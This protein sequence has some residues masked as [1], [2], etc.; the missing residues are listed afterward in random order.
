MRTILISLLIALGLS[1][2]TMA[3]A[4]AGLVEDGQAAFSA[5]DYSTA[6]RLRKEAANQ[7]NPDAQNNLGLMYRTGEGV[8]Q[9]D[10][11]AVKWFR[12]AAEQGDAEAQSNLA[13]LGAM[14][15]C[16]VV[17]SEIPD[18]YL[19]IREA[20][21]A[22]AAVRYKLHPGD[23]LA[24]SL[25][26]EKAGWR[27]VENAYTTREGGKNFDIG[28]ARERYFTR[29]ECP[30]G[31][32]VATPTVV[33]S[34]GRTYYVILGA[35]SDPVAARKQLK[36]LQANAIE[37]VIVDTDDYEGMTPNLYA[38]AQGAYSR[39]NALA[40]AADLRSVVP[41]AYVK[42]AVPKRCVDVVLSILDTSPAFIERTNGLSEAVQNNGGSGFALMI[43]S[44]PLL[45]GD[46]TWSYSKAFEISLGENY[47][48]RYLVIERYT[49]D[50]EAQKLYNYD[51]VE[52][53]L[54]QLSFDKGL[55]QEVNKL[56]K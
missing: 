55:I 16:A 39:E 29:V 20:P 45:S 17:N 28:W 25:S 52:D 56:C 8:P 34:T 19:N 35:F 38:L 42:H 51:I 43:E 15:W 40:I 21:S 12:L 2:T 49:F 44:G 48:D 27:L 24:L 5:G 23:V 32:S 54:E 46:D 33:P 47:P 3:A 18:G 13:A 30:D 31:W 50:L 1:L 7:G 22:D 11:E 36:K 10:A 14:T 41:D 6:M 37:A 4:T 26:D 9:D 53:K